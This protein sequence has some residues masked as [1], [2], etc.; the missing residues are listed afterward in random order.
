MI[1]YI[2]RN[3]IKILLLSFGF[4]LII[5]RVNIGT[6]NIILLL[7]FTM[8]FLELIKIHVFLFTW[9][10]IK[11]LLEIICNILEV[12]LLTISFYL[13]VFPVASMQKILGKDLL[14]TDFRQNPQKSFWVIRKDIRDETE[15]YNQY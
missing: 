14:D 5:F 1:D 2:L 8:L 12:C 6:R 11:I 7:F 13:F 10:V 4:A 15:Y 3:K 9:K